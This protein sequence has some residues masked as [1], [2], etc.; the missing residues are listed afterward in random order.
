M[1]FYVP[2]LQTMWVIITH[3]HSKHIIHQNDKKKLNEKTLPTNAIHTKHNSNTKQLYAH[4]RT[5][6]ETVLN[7][8]SVTLFSHLQ[9][10]YIKWDSLDYK[11]VCLVVLQQ[12]LIVAAKE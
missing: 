8:S 1:L 10:N 4:I 11:D 7:H 2:A 6:V 3:Y 5:C 12:K 9:A